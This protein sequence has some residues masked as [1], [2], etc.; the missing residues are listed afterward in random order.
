MVR[1]LKELVMFPCHSSI[2]QITFKF[3]FPAGGDP[4]LFLSS[5]LSFCSLCEIICIVSVVV[6]S[7]FSVHTVSVC[8]CALLWIWLCTCVNC[9]TM[10]V[11][12]CWIRKELHVCWMDIL[13]YAFYVCRYMPL[14][15]L[16]LLLVMLTLT[17]FMCNS[18]PLSHLVTALPS[19]NVH[20]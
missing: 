11:R 3:F 13:H 9:V 12:C 1:V 5:F 14:T 10:C 16:L 15:T 6:R 8:G 2:C 18:P 7:L 19:L 4:Y 17:L 20:I